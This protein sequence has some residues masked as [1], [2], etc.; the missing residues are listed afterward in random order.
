GL[1]IGEAPAPVLEAAVTVL[2]GGTE[3]LHHAVEGQELDGQQISHGFTSHSDLA[4]RGGSDSVRGRYIGDECGG[5]GARGERRD[6]G[7]QA[8][9]RVVSRQKRYADPSAW[10]IDLPCGN[11]SRPAHKS[12]Q[13]VALSRGSCHRE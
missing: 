6:V 12:N 7:K 8:V 10:A 11:R 4:G 13:K 9:R 5:R 1:G 2:V 3:A